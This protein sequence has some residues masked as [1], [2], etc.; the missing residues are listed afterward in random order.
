MTA[1]TGN[2]LETLRRQP[3]ISELSM[4]VFQPRSI[5]KC[6]VNDSGITDGART[7][8]YD[9]VSLG[10]YS[11]VEAG[12][13][14]LIGT[15]AGD[16]DIG[17]VRIR[18]ATSS[19][20][21]VAENSIAW[22]NNLFLTVLRY[23]EVWPIYPRIISD[24]ADA[25]NV[26]FYKDYD[27]AYTDQNSKFGA[28][29]CAGPHRAAY[30]D[31]STG[32]ARVYW[33]SEDTDPI[34]G[35]ISSYEWAFEG[36]IPTG[37]TSATPGYVEYS[38]PGHYVTRLKVTTSLGVTDT[39]YRYVSIYN[40]PG[41]GS[42]I[43]PQK[44]ILQ[45]MSGSRGE[46]GYSLSIRLY[47]NLDSIKDGSVIVL[48]GDDYYGGTLASLGGDALG[49]S[50]IFFVGY[51]LKNSIHYNYAYSYVDFRVGSIT[52]QMKICEGFSVSVEDKPSPA[53]WFEVENMSIDRAMY[54]YLKWHSTVLSVADFIYT[55]NGSQRHQYYDSDRESLFDAIDNFLRSAVVGQIT[56][57]RQGR[58]YGEVN[59]EAV[60]NATGTFTPIMTLDKRDWMNE[61]S[62]T[63]N[64]SPTVSY[65]EMGGIA[66]GSV[67][68]TT[69]YGALLAC[70]PGDAPLY[71]GKATRQS[72]LVLDSQSQLNILVG[73]VLANRN[74]RYPV[75]DVPMAGSYKNMDIAPQEAVRVVINPEDTVRGISID[76]PYITQGVSYTYDHRVG[77]L[78]AQANLG[79]VTSGRAGKTIE[80]PVIPDDGGFGNP[81]INFPPSL[82][83]FPPVSFAFPSGTHA[84]TFGAWLCEASDSGVA[85]TFV[86]SNKWTWSFES[87]FSD[88][89]NGLWEFGA[90]LGP[91]IPGIHG[92]GIRILRNGFYLLGLHG[93]AYSSEAKKFLVM[94]TKNQ[95][96]DASPSQTVDL[97][98]LSGIPDI[99]TIDVHSIV[100]L[101]AGDILHVGGEFAPVALTSGGSYSIS[102]QFSII[103]L[104]DV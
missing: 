37:S 27:I 51:V 82:V 98:T 10:G 20:F 92:P 2:E 17:R 91:G 80:I 21:I 55:G 24:P 74:T 41:Y 7:I 104:L 96:F 6:L 85:T 49:N 102:V 22:A 44:W 88:Y 18:S 75:I 42:S 86:S 89:N 101:V 64:L 78:M 72:G 26:I 36:G 5:M 35:T 53:T 100:Y 76:A 94:V 84:T 68:G 79:A 3:K 15:S 38:T 67:T 87:G 12:M 16:D 47:E 73:N 30:I 99:T 81:R 4:S 83:T 46:G 57:N 71:R 95:D 50:N 33:S 19:Q 9:T 45:E 103:L 77:L 52:E 11:S 61:P 48:Y 69:N 63:E 40:K 56:S 1:L 28:F 43:P 29:V 14:L 34:K 25:E 97:T 23:W 60:P 66:Y 58:I 62:I 65:L 32:K 90:S 93:G 59:A 31:E 39:T 13:T 70:A 54:H 8:T